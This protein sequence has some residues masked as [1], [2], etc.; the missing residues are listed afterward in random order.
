[1]TQL[2]KIRF[3]YWQW[4]RKNLEDDFGDVLKP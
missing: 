2:D 3:N 1:M 4:F